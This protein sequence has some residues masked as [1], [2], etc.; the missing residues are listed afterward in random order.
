MTI[1][2]YVLVFALGDAK[3]SDFSATKLL[4]K[5]I[6]SGL[7]RKISITIAFF[8]LT[9]LYRLGYSSFKTLVPNHF[10]PPNIGT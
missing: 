5:D 6:F 8:V 10:Q 7:D 2:K 4:L 1:E 9:I 3:N